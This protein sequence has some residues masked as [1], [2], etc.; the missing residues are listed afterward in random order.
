MLLVTRQWAAQGD[1]LQPEDLQALATVDQRT[2]GLWFFNSGPDAGA[3][4]PHR[5]IQLLPRRD[6]ASI[7]PREPWFL[8][9]LAAMQSTQ[10]DH[11]RLESGLCS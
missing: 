11:S 6:V 7:C 5:H 1:W 8:E 9:R 10:R 2:S 3:S 4:Q